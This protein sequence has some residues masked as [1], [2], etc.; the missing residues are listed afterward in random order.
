MQN[1][2]GSAADQNLIRLQLFAGRDGG[3]ELLGV[4]IMIAARAGEHLG[5]GVY[6]KLRRTIGVLVGVQQYQPA[7]VPAPGAALRI[8]SFASNGEPSGY[9][10]KSTSKIAASQHDAS[11]FR[12]I[13]QVR[14]LRSRLRFRDGLF[15]SMWITSKRTVIRD[16]FRAGSHTSF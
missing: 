4:F 3:A 13:P 7:Q 1:F 11:W 2:A 8:G 14:F 10:S 12:I 5:H 15:S 6:R 16:V 9:H